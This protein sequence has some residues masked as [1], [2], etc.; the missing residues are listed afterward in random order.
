MKA[1]TTRIPAPR[2]AAKR[3]RS[4]DGLGS[5]ARIA[6]KILRRAARPEMPPPTSVFEWGNPECFYLF[7]WMQPPGIDS[8]AGGFAAGASS[9]PDNLDV[10]EP[11]A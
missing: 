7:D 1:L 3:K 4:T 9:F 11:R 2:P 5:F 10:I 6:R 8:I